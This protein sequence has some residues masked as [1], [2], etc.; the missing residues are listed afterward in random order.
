MGLPVKRIQTLGGLA[1]FEGT[2]PLGGTAQQPRRLALLAVLARAGE[3]GVNRDR[4]AALFWGEQEEERARRSLNQALYALRQ[5]L[6]SEETILGTRELRL[7]SE[8][9]EVDVLAFEAAV[10]SGALEDAARLYGGP[11]LGDF[12]LPGVGEFARWAEGERAGL[13]AEYRGLLQALATSAT[14]RGDGSGAVQWWRRLA[15]MDPADG[16]AAQGLMRALVAVGDVP[17]ALRHAEVFAAVRQG[18]LELPPDAGVVALAERIRSGEVAPP[19]PRAEPASPVAATAPEELEPSGPE[20]IRPSTATLPATPP[21]AW[22]RWAA[23]ALVALAVIAAIGGG[24]RWRTASHPALRQSVVAIAPFD[25]FDSTHILWREGLVDLL[26]RNLDG[27]GPLTTVPPTVVVRRW[28]GRADPESA[29]ELGRRTGAELALYGSLLG[30]GRDSVRVRAT[31]FDVAGGETLGEWEVVDAAD[32]MDRLTDSLTLQLLRGLGRTRPIGAVRL[33][34]FRGTSLPVIKAFLQGEQHYRRSEWDSALAF[35][36]RAIDLDGNFAPALRRASSAIGWRGRTHTMMVLEYAARAGANNHGLPP[37]DSLLVAAD[38]KI[39]ALLGRSESDT[40]WRTRIRDLFATLE[41]ITTRYP[42][43]PEGWYLLGDAQNHFGPFAGR[44]QQQ[45]LEAFDRAIALD[46]AFAPSYLHPIEIAG[47]FGED[48]VRRYLRPYLALVRDESADGPRLVQRL[49]DSGP[50]ADPPALFQGVSD[51]GLFIAM[52]ALGRLPDSTEWIVSLDRFIG[53]RPRTPHPIS[54]TASMR[55]ET[56]R[57]LMSRGHLRAG[58]ELLNGHEQSPNFAE[59][60]LLGVVPVER[61]AAVFRERLSGPVSARLVAAFPWWTSRAD[62]ASLQ[63]AA[64]HASTLAHQPQAPADHLVTRYAAASATAYLTLAR[65]DTTA[66]LGQ[67]L[68]LPD[69]DCPDCYLDRLT[70]VQLLVE[71]RRDRE[72][73]LMLQPEHAIPTIGPYATEVLWALLRGRVGERLAQRDRAVQSYAW[74]A[75]MW[76]N[77]DPEL[78]PYVREA[79]EGLARLTGE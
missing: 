13:A 60:A 29:A 25:V 74:V 18:E 16:P 58:L 73:W 19:A 39:F 45:Q 76:R 75:G 46:S 66:A 21:R 55:V 37:R 9:V 78:Q 57:A 6:G 43:D 1:V 31:L 42:D 59:A 10:A 2:R 77:A 79:R 51:E 34:G 23:G 67:F 15:A 41:H 44:S 27:A 65:K 52:I 47:V 62:T 33:V 69:G 35:Y 8:L 24:L 53:S 68:S 64:T 14:Q 40:T 56:A 70:L 4:L 7:N 38:S 72:A 22:S 3:R 32:R 63:R 26:S 54:D 61:A 49:L 17:G 48:A 30:A 5:D 11:F 50:S 20:E 71:R 28:T 12:H 36:Q